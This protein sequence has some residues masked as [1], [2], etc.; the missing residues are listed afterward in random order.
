MRPALTGIFFQGNFPCR[1]FPVAFWFKKLMSTSCSVI[2]R[3]SALSA[4]GSGKDLSDGWVVNFA[5]GC[6]HGCLFCYVDRIWRLH[7]S[8]KHS[9]YYGLVLG[10]WGQY[11]YIPSD[12]EEQIRRTPWRRWSNR[13]LLMSSTHDPYLPELYFPHRWPRKILEAAL[14]YGV[15]FTILTRST[16]AMQDFDLYAKYRGQVT[17]MSSIPT[18]DDGFAKITEPRAPPPTARLRMLK[19]AKELGIPIGVVVAPIIMRRGWREDLE[20]LFNALAELEP[21]VVYGES[22][23]AR[24]L[25]L[26]RLRAAGVEAQ[27]GPAADREVG[28]V[29]EELLKRYGLRGAY[30]YEWGSEAD[31]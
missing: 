5:F 14:P 13:R 15:K 7:A 30:W 12:L 10:E 28:R 27:V 6:T 11:L 25:N 31:C 8:N 24:G 1:K 21:S 26:A 22:L 23:H 3:R 20:R 9:P 29:F 16:L 19:R 4:G 18:L 17:L 2:V